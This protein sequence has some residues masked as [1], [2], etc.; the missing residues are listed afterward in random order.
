MLKLSVKKTYLTIFF[1]IL[2]LILSFFF[3][4]NNCLNK[5]ARI[6]SINNK[7]YCLLTADNQEEWERGLMFY[8]KPVDFEG[9]IFIFPNKEIKSFWNENTYMDLDLYWMDGD[10]VVG[11]SY[12]PSIIKTKNPFT[13]SSLREVDRIVEIIK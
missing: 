9:M 6:Y 10:K 7:N 11:K 2:L 8:K 12:L 4:K 3:K 1:L 13:V 5:Q